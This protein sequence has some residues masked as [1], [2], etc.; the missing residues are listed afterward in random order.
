MGCATDQIKNTPVVLIVDGKLG[1]TIGQLI[2]RQVT[3]P[4]VTTIILIDAGLVCAS[5]VVQIK[6]QMWSFR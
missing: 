5:D 6:L 3:A 4:A 1:S 2:D